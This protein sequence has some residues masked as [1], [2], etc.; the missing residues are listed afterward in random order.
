MFMSHIYL[1]NHVEILSDIFPDRIKLCSFLLTVYDARLV[2]DTPHNLG[3]REA[4]VCDH[5]G[6]RRNCYPGLQV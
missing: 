1:L 2:F 4:Q 6:H 3:A 5:G